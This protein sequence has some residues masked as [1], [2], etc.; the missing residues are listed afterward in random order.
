MWKIIL[1]NFIWL[2][3]YFLFIIVSNIPIDFYDEEKKKKTHTE[4]EKLYKKKEKE[5]TRSG[6]L[7]FIP[8]PNALSFASKAESVW[9]WYIFYSPHVGW[10]PGGPY[11]L[12]GKSPLFFNADCIFSN[13]CLTIGIWTQ[14]S[15][16]DQSV[17]SN[18]RYNGKFRAKMAIFD[19]CCHS[20]N[21]R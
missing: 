14:N 19:R 17:S 8:P 11:T 4:K 9:G 2:F 15:I 12:A 16:A 13:F 6:S 21:I 10:C 20:N 1:E 3:V 18:R 5:Y 7:H